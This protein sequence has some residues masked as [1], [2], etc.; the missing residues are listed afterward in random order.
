MVKKKEDPAIPLVGEHNSH[1]RR[2]T[3]PRRDLAFDNEACQ[4]D[5]R[6]Q[7]E[8]EED[9][10]P[11]PIVTSQP[12]LSVLGGSR[13]SRWD[14]IS[15]RLLRRKQ[16]LWR[17]RLLVDL[18]VAVA[19]LGV[20]VMLAETELYIQGIVSKADPVSWFLRM[21]VSLS[22]VVLLLTV[23]AYNVTS[24]QM[25]MVNNSLDDWRLAVTPPFVCNV[26]L[27]LAVCSVHP[28]PVSLHS[29][30]Q[31]KLES[32]L[33]VLMFLRL[34][35]LARFL[36]VH[37]RYLTDTATRSLGALNKVRIDALFV[38]KALMSEWPGSMLLISMV[39]IFLLSGWSVRTCE[40]YVALAEHR[41]LNETPAGYIPE[42]FWFSAIT[43]LTVG[44][45]DV[46]PRSEC[47][48]VAAVATG[49]LGVGVTALL[50][51]VLATKLQQSR[52]EKYVHTFISRIDLD[53]RQ[54]HAAADVIKN[55]I[56]L[57]RMR[58]VSGLRADR[59]RVRVHGKL[60]QAIRN[61]REAKTAK[62]NI[63]EAAV[64]VIEVNSGVTALA[65]TTEL[66][67]VQLDAVREKT[68]E[69]ENHLFAMDSKLDTIVTAMRQ[70]S[71]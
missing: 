25:T 35:L 28:L 60:L 57:W 47:G 63:G 53:K 71:T 14:N 36:V 45:G 11:P 4:N 1:F 8:V 6:A 68:D 44:Y 18:A 41:A 43:F 12:R 23:V 16:L 37:S 17:W 49:L 15:Y 55:V 5:W 38:F 7:Q 27:E 2:Y 26:A 31:P 69:M 59:M 67:M 34:Y 65:R 54:K 10:V 9:K 3:D 42:A 46:V 66:L 62:V 22:T 24:V 13:P 40:A 20:V 21:V 52:A 30:P 29:G 51:A 39:A 64:G 58:G 33:S 61:M 32:V 19:G 70:R 50:V 48:R 56:K